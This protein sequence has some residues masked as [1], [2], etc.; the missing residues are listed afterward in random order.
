MRGTAGSSGE[1]ACSRLGKQQDVLIFSAKFCTRNGV[2]FGFV[3]LSCLEE[4]FF[5][6]PEGEGMISTRFV[7]C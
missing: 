2:M 1:G 6:L 3:E 7:E 4:L 5:F